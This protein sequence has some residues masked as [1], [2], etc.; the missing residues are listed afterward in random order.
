MMI[1]QDSLI[2]LVAIAAITLIGL[3]FLIT[4]SQ[5]RFN[6]QLNKYGSLTIEGKSSSSEQKQDG[7]L[8]G[9]DN[10]RRLNC[11]H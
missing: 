4:N 11:N 10:S 2:L 9:E 1:S 5:G 8:P 6:I 7:C 3:T